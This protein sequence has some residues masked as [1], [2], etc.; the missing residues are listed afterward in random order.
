[1]EELLVV[2]DWDYP[3][4]LAFEERRFIDKT[5]QF[6]IENLYGWWNTIHVND[7]DDDGDLDLV[8]GNWGTNNQFKLSQEEPMILYYDDFDENGYID[9]I[10]SYFN[11][12]NQ[13]PFVLKDELTD[14]IVSLRKKYVTYASFANETMEDIFTTE[15]LDESPK[16]YTNFL[17]TVWFENKE[18]VFVK[19]KLPNEVNISSIHA[20]YVYDFDD[21]GAKDMF[22]AGNVP[23]N[24]VRIGRRESTFGI[25]LKGDG[26]GNFSYISNRETGIK[27][28]GSVRSLEMIRTSD[29][30][31]LVVG[32]NNS[33]PLIITIN[34]E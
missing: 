33:K 26:K 32:V 13:Y 24:R 20:I 25:Y 7:V 31:K 12:D 21:D 15:Q 18:G 34:N 16:C 30:K 19:R 5:A 1:M 2:G 6:F 9:P 4:V 27:I 10:W 29:N 8:L 17:E 22:L 3:R 23:F 14:Q 28:N 11:N